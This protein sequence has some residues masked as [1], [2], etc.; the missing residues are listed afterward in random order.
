M[1][2]TI[3]QNLFSHV[4]FAY[5]DCASSTSGSQSFLISALSKRHDNSFSFKVT[6]IK[7]MLKFLWPLLIVN[8]IIP[9]LI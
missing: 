5:G 6:K 1:K 2:C 8:V 4:H 9:G 3:F 7:A